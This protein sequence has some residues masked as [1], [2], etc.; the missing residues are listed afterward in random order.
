MAE[1]KIAPT[2]LKPIQ[3]YLKIAEEHEKR[4]PAITYWCKYIF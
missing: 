1:L 3:A 2:G 4:D